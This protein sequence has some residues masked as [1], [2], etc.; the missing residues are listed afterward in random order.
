MT[1]YRVK[2]NLLNLRS[3]PDGSIVGRLPLNTLVESDL[4]VAGTGALRTGWNDPETP[5]GPRLSNDWVR[6]VKV[7][8]PGEDWAP[9]SGFAALE[10]LAE[11]R[12]PADL[13]FVSSPRITREKF[14]QVLVSAQSPAAKEAE[15]LY[16]VPVS[17]GLDPAVALAF[18]AHESAF[19]KA[20]K[21]VRTKNWGNLRRGQGRAY[22]VSEGF[23]FY[24]TWE[25]GLHDWCRLIRTVYVDT[26]RLTTVR[27][28]LVKYAPG[29]DG[30]NPARYGDAV[31]HLVEEW[32]S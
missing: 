7:Q 9:L 1:L 10:W 21:A 25:D 29:S 26:W 31:V 8:K 14:I 27:A 5:Q 30:N 11:E 15:S 17:F 16:R 12:T 22:K 23:A 32:S 4:L 20:G 19:G 18:F 24:R 13:T 3:A 2:A 28:A 6:V